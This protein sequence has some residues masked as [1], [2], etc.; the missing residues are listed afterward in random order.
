MEKIILEK[1]I[2][3]HIEN[4]FN[5]YS[6]YLNTDIQVF[7]ELRYSVEEVANCLMFGLDKAA[8]TLT[9]NILARLLKLSLI[10]NLVG[11]KP[12]PIE[13]W[14]SAFDEANRKYGLLPLGKTI[15][16]CKKHNLILESE[17]VYL[18]DAVK[19]LIINGYLNADFGKM[20]DILTEEA[21]VKQKII[22]PL[23]SIQVENFTKANASRYFEFVFE[24]I[25]NIAN[26]LIEKGK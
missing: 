5:Q 16:L 19:K 13:K 11:I 10:Y 7:I 22:P 24:L 21:E 9:N 12:V 17:K 25:G 14:N 6:K 26:R 3:S 4:N 15:E 18:V 23:Q 2:K 20:T 8:I 1:T